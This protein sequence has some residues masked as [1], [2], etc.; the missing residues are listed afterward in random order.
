MHVCSHRAPTLPGSPSSPGTQPGLQLKISNSQ[1]GDLSLTGP[2]AHSSLLCPELGLGFLPLLQPP[3][4]PVFPQAR[5]GLG[6]PVWD[7]V[8]QPHPR[9]NFRAHWSRA[10][11]YVLRGSPQ[12]H[13]HGSSAHPHKV[14]QC[15]GQA[16]GQGWGAHRA[17]AAGVGRGEDAE[18]QLEGQNQ[19]HHHGLAGR[20]VFV[21]LQGEGGLG[22]PSASMAKSVGKWV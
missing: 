7:R 18:R 6:D 10:P 16:N 13:P 15:D 17:G 4:I 20:R 9:P 1:A 11:L 3:L 8:Q 14:A 22:L 2:C 5:E 19:L 12:P 21:E